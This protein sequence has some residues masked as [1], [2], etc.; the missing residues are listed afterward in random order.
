MDRGGSGRA[1]FFSSLDLSAPVREGEACRE[2]GSRRALSHMQEKDW[3]S[4]RAPAPAPDSRPR[5]AAP[6]VHLF[7]VGVGCPVSAAWRRC[8]LAMHSARTFP[9]EN[10]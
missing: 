10:I 9:E 6:C 2:R 7:W 5:H 3:G 4:P 8:P 1:E